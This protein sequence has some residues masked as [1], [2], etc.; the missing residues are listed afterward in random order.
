MR[1][2]M[3]RLSCAPVLAAGITVVAAAGLTT[4]PV[5]G[6]TQA[7]APQAPAAAAAPAS[8]SASW[9]DVE[10]E[11]FLLKARVV[12]TRPAGKGVTDSIRATMT[13]GV[14]TH[15]AHIQTVEQHKNVFQTKAGVE[16]NFRDTW[17]FNVA[18]YRLDRLIGLN[19]VPVSVERRWSGDLAS[20]TWWVDDVLTDEEGRIKKNL[21][22]PDA[23]A[24]YEQIHHIRLFDQL[25][26]NMD[27]NQGNMLITTDWRIWAID[28]TRA[29]RTGKDLRNPSYIRRIDRQV[30]ERLKA[31]D[32]DGLRKGLGPF[33]RDEEIDGVLARR[34]V[35]VQL[36]EGIGP[37]AVFDRVR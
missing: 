22:A 27:R 1:R 28:H 2:L 3:I 31:M 30:L 4:H 6:A 23:V 37:P 5:A 14:V 32:R 17:Q 19:M 26:R 15:D 21:S 9:T 12:K 29:F 36:L 24:W 35:I 7:V 8:P 34:D 18:A 16:L 25:I 11:S 33:L 10:I 20:Y 13:D